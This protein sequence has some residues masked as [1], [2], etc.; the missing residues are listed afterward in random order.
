MTRPGWTSSD[1]DA[2]LHTRREHWALEAMVDECGDPRPRFASWT[3][4]QA[5]AHCR[6]I[7]A[8]HER[9]YDHETGAT[10]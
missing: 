1:I 5:L 7:A 6:N 2:E 9:A 10:R 3:P 8:E 4:A